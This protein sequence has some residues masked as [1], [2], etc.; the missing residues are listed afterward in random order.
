M[1]LDYRAAGFWL[2][3]AQWAFNVIVLVWMAINRKHQ[4]DNKRVKDL[5]DSNATKITEKAAKELINEKI[6]GCADH[7]K[8]TESLEKEVGRMPSASDL[9][10]VHARMD[11][12]VSVVNNLAGEMKATTNQMNLVLQELLR[13]EKQ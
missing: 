8:R 2:T 13:R 7:L 5:E 3:V 4:A 10:R 1:D 12:A 11:E 9:T 6:N